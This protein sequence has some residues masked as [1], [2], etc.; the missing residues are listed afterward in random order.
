MVTGCC[1]LRFELFSCLICVWRVGYLV[2]WG[3]GAWC[4]R[5]GLVVLIVLIVLVVCF[6]LFGVTADFGVFVGCCIDLNFRLEYLSVI[7]GLGWCL[8]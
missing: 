2:C 8:L 4:C 3:L 5:C 1:R 7:A 6:R